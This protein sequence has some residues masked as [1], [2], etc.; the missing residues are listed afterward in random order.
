M[1]TDLANRQVELLEKVVIEG[2]L[3]KLSA[4]ERME[5]YEW[6]ARRAASKSISANGSRG[7]VLRPARATG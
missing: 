4:A 5:C 1:V 6:N 3:E 7:P 2:D